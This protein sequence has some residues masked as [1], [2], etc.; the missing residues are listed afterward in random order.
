MIEHELVKE[1]IIVEIDFGFMLGRSTM[2]AIYL[3]RRLMEKFGRKKDL[4]L[5]FMDI[6]KVYDTL[7]DFAMN[8]RGKNKYQV[9]IFTLS[10]ICSY[11]YC[12]E[13]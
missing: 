7:R 12:M 5:V 4:E 9:V 6:G 10:W 1:T 8:F 11:N 13:N 2:K 3:L